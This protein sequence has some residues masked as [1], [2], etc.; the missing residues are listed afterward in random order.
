MIQQLIDSVV[1]SV[2]EMVVENAENIANW[3][4]YCQQVL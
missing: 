1:N 3:Y 2:G 4:L